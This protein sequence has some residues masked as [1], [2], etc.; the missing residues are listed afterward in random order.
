MAGCSPT[1]FLQ[2]DELLLKG[3]EVVMD[4][5]K[6]KSGGKEYS[7]MQQR[8]N[9][10]VA[11]IP[12][13]M[14][15]YNAG[16]PEREK[17]FKKWLSKIGEKP[18]IVDTALVE[19]TANQLYR[20]YFNRGYFENE[21]SWEIKVKSKRR[22]HVVYYATRGEPYLIRNIAYTISPSELEEFV[23]RQM[24]LLTFKSGDIYNLET[25]DKERARLTAYFKDKGF[26]DFSK[27]YI[28]YEV[29]SAI[30]GRF[31]DI[32]IGFENKPEQSTDTVAYYP[33]SAY[34]INKII[35]INS[36]ERRMDKASFPDT[37]NHLGY[38]F[39]TNGDPY[40]RM[41]TLTD[42]IHYNVGDRY[43]EKHV[44]DSYQHLVDL[45]LF[46]NVKLEFLPT[47]GDT[48]RSQLDAFVITQPFDRQNTGIEGVGTH[49]SG[50][51]GIGGSFFYQNNNIFRGGE[52]WDM[53][54]RLSLEAQGA[55]DVTTIFNTREV[56]IETSLMLPRL[57][58]PFNTEGFMPK[59]YFPKT[60]LKFG[61]YN[62]VRVDFTRNLFSLSY[63][64]FFR[65]SQTKNH[66]IDLPTLSYVKLVNIVDSTFLNSQ[67]IRTGYEDAFIPAIAYTFVYNN[68]ELTQLGNYDFYRG[69][70]ELA[71]TLVD[72]L[73]E[74]FNAPVNDKGQRMFFGNPYAQF[75][76]V[77]NDYRYYFGRYSRHKTAMRVFAGGAFK[78]G[79][80]Q[81]I[82]FEK[83]FFGGGSNDM[84][85]WVAY[86]LYP[87]SSYNP[88]ITTL[89][90]DIKIMLTAEYRF[91]I[92][93]GLNGALF[94]DAGNI[95]LS[96]PEESLPGGE[97][98]FNRFYKE[99]AIGVGVGIRYDF[100]FFLIRLDAGVKVRQP[101]L[102][103]GNRWTPEN[104]NFANAVWNFGIG[105]PF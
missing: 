69:R 22:A 19:K 58:M 62:Q 18:S 50:N 2:Q 76:K 89:T 34:Y 13:Y 64:Y 67:R 43:Y 86:T 47:P 68:Q 97:F 104:L 20:Y 52:I 95:W 24:P 51:F 27:E 82:P 15:M 32:T 96:S 79:N 30:E 23:L 39:L 78:F 9:K 16:D 44:Q 53:R 41:R 3:N 31:V 77:E 28:Y 21:I 10:R 83:Q 85:S 57:I 93:G 14:Y 88:E 103:E 25:I 100:D 80:S 4:G 17:G 87:G 90:G 102:Q 91:N 54:F 59:R 99:F 35:V 55:T 73:A 6:L 45:K 48:T 1:K 38:T 66:Q 84:R 101:E 46:R 92:L 98:K 60:Q 12:F 49:A 63:S 36:F 75:L 7:Y 61:F 40:F 5:Q 42:A 81:V 26:Y 8:P 33:H 11:G 37:L 74:L 70:V 56:G 94:S 71:G 29:D 72:A 105:Y 65:E